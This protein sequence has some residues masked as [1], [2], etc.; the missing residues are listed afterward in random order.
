MK[1]FIIYMFIARY[2][3]RWSSHTTVAT[4]LSCRRFRRCRWWN[5]GYIKYSY[6]HNCFIL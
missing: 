1:L 3:K 2:A 5:I 4:E 6:K